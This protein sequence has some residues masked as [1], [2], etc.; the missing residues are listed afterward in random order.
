VAV[1]VDGPREV[2]RHTVVWD[3]TDK[4]GRTVSDGLYLC[5]IEAGSFKQTKKLLLVK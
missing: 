4:T 5:R 1:L 2:G 3:G